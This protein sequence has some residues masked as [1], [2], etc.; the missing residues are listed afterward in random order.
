MRLDDLDYEFLLM[1]YQNLGYTGKM[2][3]K[4]LQMIDPYISFSML[5]IINPE[6]DF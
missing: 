2:L 3:E 6:L 4:K 5:R 1:K